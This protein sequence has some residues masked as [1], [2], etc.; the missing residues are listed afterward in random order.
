[1]CTQ[2]P[3]DVETR[4]VDDLLYLGEAKVQFLEE[5]DLLQ[6]EQGLLAIVTVTVLAMA[7]R[8]EEP[9]LIVEMKGTSAD[10]GQVRELL[11][12]MGHIPHL[13]AHS[14]L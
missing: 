8:F 9:D 14:T 10:A 11:H 1:M 3:Q 4:P 13:L 6:P 7:R 12:G 5:H 2:G